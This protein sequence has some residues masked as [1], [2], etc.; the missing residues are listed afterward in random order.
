MLA[1]IACLDYRTM[2][3]SPITI[4]NPEI[5]ALI[6]MVG[7][8][9]VTVRAFKLE[10]EDICEDYG[11]IA[12]YSG[13][14]PNHP[15]YFDLDDHHRLFTGKPELVCSNT[16]AMLRDTRFGQHFEVHGDTS[17]HFGVF[18]CAPAVDKVQP[19]SGG[20]CC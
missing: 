15:H 11:Q 2:A 1:R 8:S 10:L 6:G 7:F 14:I 13:T 9:S 4:D 18:D 16:A 12:V 5:E 17:V 19:A 3:S 20:A